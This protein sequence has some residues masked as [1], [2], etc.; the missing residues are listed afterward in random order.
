MV[1]NLFRLILVLIVIAFPA[2]CNSGIV[3]QQV[4]YQKGSSERQSGNILIEDNRLRFNDLDSNV[5]SI[6]DIQNDRILLLDHNKRTYV[7]TTVEEYLATASQMMREMEQDMKEHLS[8]LPPEQQDTLKK[9]MKK[10]DL[11]S[12]KS[13]SS[14]L[15]VK[16]TQAVATIANKQASKYEVYIDGKLYEE[17]WIGDRSDYSNE[18]DF[19]KISAM[20]KRFKVVSTGHSTNLIVND[21]QYTK[22]FQKGFPLKTVNYSFNKSVYVEE[23]TDIKT[24]EVS[25]EKF[26]P[27]PGYEEVPLDSLFK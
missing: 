6:I 23:V 20:M 5:S 11:E 8:V 26:R 27:E 25:E 7:E 19:S 10:N 2:V 14:T 12:D 15:D 4:R 24:E 9:L 1:C 13:K 16:N 3:M 17:I 22:L 21:E 18:V